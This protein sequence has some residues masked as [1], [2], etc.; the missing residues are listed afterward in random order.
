MYK[1]HNIKLPYINTHGHSI[2]FRMWS[3]TNLNNSHISDGLFGYERLCSLII[4]SHS[5]CTSSS[6][7]TS[8]LKAHKPGS[9][10]TPLKSAA[11]TGYDQ[12]L[13]P[14]SCGNECIVK[15]RPLSDVWFLYGLILWVF[16]VHWISFKV[17][18]NNIMGNNK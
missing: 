12:F 16:H 9:S 4:I 18:W 7:R 5:S 11:S 6:H 1:Y 14:S 3:H 8:R 17:S 10:L 2:S 15:G 13:T